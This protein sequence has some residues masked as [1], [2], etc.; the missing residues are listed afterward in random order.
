MTPRQ[1]WLLAK[2][3]EMHLKLEDRRTGEVV[4]MLYN[5]NRDPDKDP[6]GMTWID[7]F[8]HWKTEAEQSEEDMLETMLIL[9]K[10]TEGLPA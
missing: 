10:A 7:V 4:A 9:A 1:F 6:R 2:R 5:I 3:L 8:P